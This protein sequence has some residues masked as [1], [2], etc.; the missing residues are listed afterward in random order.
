[1]WNWPSAQAFPRRRVCAGDRHFELT[2]VG[3]SEAGPRHLGK[4]RVLRGGCATRN[5][6][7]RLL[8]PPRRLR[9]RPD[10]GSALVVDRPQIAEVLDVAAG[11]ATGTAGAAGAEGAEP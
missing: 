5:M 6:S 9:P 11:A 2:A 7:E 4:R 8:R 10:P 1:M 3:A